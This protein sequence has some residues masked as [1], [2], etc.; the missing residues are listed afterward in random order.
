M[1][2]MSKKKVTMCD[3]PSGWRYGFPKPQPSDILSREEF[4]DWLVSEG[5][6]RKMIDDYGDHFYCRYWVVESDEISAR[7]EK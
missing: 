1:R 7:G 5:Y 3:P 6:P 4:H 2:I